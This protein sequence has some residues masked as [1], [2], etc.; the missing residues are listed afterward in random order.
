MK[1][2]RSREWLE[3]D[4]LGGFASGTVSGIR[5]R[6]YHALLLTARTP[7]TSRVVLVNG[8]DAWVETPAGR[9][10]I[11]SQ[12]YGGDVTY[13]DGASRLEAFDL[14]PWPRWTFALEDGTR[15]TQEILVPKEASAAALSWR[16]LSGD[17]SDHA[18]GPSVPLRAGL[19]RPAP[20][21]RR[22]SV[23]RRGRGRRAPALPDLSGH[24]VRD[25]AHQRKL[26]RRRR[27]GTAT[28]FTPRNAPAA[29]TSPRTSPRPGPCA[30]SCR[31]ARRSG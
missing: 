23:R 7:P 28:S 26:R 6:R 22:P 19:S 8:F 2:T 24:A 10:A 3:A 15:L 12:A 18:G 11:T 13:P 29:S 30:S 25:H 4:G 21:E 1:D 17:G 14:E 16:L 20:R 31:G 5:T 9:Y 27:T